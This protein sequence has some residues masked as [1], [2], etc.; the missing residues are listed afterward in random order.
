MKIGCV[1]WCFH[2]FAAGT[3]PEE[4]IEIIGDLGF[5]GTD[6]IVLGRK[7]LTE[8][9]NDATIDRLKK[10]L[11]YHQLADARGPAGPAGAV[12]RGQEV[13]EPQAQHPR[14]KAL[15]RTLSAEAERL[16]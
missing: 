2:S 6:L 15:R 12:L 3:N 16:R 1:S 13:P 8:Y 11:E 7:D 5:D 14:G 9:W 4:A 10:R